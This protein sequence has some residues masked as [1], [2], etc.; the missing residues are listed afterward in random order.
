VTSRKAERL[1]LASAGAVLALAA[2]ASGMGARAGGISSLPRTGIRLAGLS[3]V[4]D[5]VALV[6]GSVAV[7]AGIALAVLVARRPRRSSDEF[8]IVLPPL[9]SPWSR[10][11]AALVALGLIALP[12]A[13]FIGARHVDA[14][15][16][17]E[18]RLPSASIT[19]HPSS[20]ITAANASR[21]HRGSN[22]RRA[23]IIISVA[24]IVTA[25]GATG[26]HMARANATGQIAAAEVE[27][28]SDEPGLAE[29]AVASV[30]A[31]RRS[32]AEPGSARSAVISAYVAMTRTLAGTGTP[33]DPALTPRRLLA[34]AVRDG[35]VDVVPVGV[36]VDRFE[37]ARFSHH[38][39]TDDDRRRVES[40]LDDVHRQLSTAP[41]RRT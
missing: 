6:A 30:A 8:Q 41:R 17:T 10:A 28:T 20:T 40:A 5:V 29:T 4:V 2:V 32:M 34:R 12:V 13:L 39:V 31:A 38:P 7:I 26:L 15:N 14:H 37:A 11:A 23:V 16:R 35:L 27:Q 3:V 1:A 21:H 18:Q 19:P 36:I 24:V 22:P 25:A 33:T 9:G